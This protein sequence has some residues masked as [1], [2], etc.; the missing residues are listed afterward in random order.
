[1]QVDYTFLAGEYAR[2]RQVMPEVLENLVESGG[3]G[4]RSRVLDVGCGTG[5]YT[6]A[7]ENALGCACWGIDPS[8]QMLAKAL[9]Q[10]R[11]VHFSTGGAEHLD[12]PADFFDLV[13]SVDVIHHVND[14]SAFFQEAWRVLKK[15]GRVCT[16]TDSEE[17]ICH[18]QPLSVYFPE[19]VEIDLQR[20]P[21]ISALRTMMLAA[22]FTCLQEILGEHAYEL[23]EIERYRSKAYSCLHLIPAEA[24]ERGI[25]HMERDLQE[26][27]IPA[28]SRYLLL[29]GKK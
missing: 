13:F 14:R 1:M 8:G 24:F 25:Q 21:R 11:N 6:L 28:T 10:T 5:N 15:G 29:W 26:H 4:D 20:Y 3:L 27:P 7:L 19:T 9:E 23:T 16:V 2:H 12:F 18:R 22:G 17:I